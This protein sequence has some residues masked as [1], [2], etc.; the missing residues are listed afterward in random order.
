MCKHELDNRLSMIQNK[1][2]EKQRLGYEISL[3]KQDCVNIF[4][5]RSFTEISEMV[6]L[7]SAWLD[8]PK[9]I[10]NKRFTV[11]T[12]RNNYHYLMYWLIEKI[13]KNIENDVEF[14]DKLTIHDYGC[15]A[16]SVPFKYRGYEWELRIPNI[17]Q[18][19]NYDNLLTYGYYTLY[20]APSSHIKC[21]FTHYYSCEDLKNNIEIELNKKLEEYYD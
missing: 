6:D 4:K 1:E 2:L 17:K 13:F 14:Y 7:H 11:K 19:N 3:I 15:Y 16:L 21:A 18:I 12:M 10:T 9:K 20:T 8:Q 5:Q